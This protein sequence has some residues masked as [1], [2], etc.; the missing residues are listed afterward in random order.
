MEKCEDRHA[1]MA[2]GYRFHQAVAD[3]SH[4][5][6]LY[7][8]CESI[9]SQLRGL[10]VLDSL[11]I[12]IFLKGI[13]EHRHIAQAIKERNSSLAKELMLA[14]LRKDYAAYIEKTSVF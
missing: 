13:D 3:F 7:G 5:K 8:F 2:Y 6:I 4:N 11:T 9:S 10:R 1:L 14:H 12:D